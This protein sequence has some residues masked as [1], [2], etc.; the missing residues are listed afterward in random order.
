MGTIFR[1]NNANIIIPT[2]LALISMIILVMFSVFLFKISPKTNINHKKLPIILST[3]RNIPMFWCI[4]KGN[5][6][7]TCVL[8][9]SVLLIKRHSNSRS[10]ALSCFDWLLPIGVQTHPENTTLSK[11]C[12]LGHPNFL[13]L[14]I[15]FFVHGGHSL[16]K[17]DIYCSLKFIASNQITL[18]RPIYI[19]F[20][21][22]VQWFCILEE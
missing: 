18:T 2:A 17:K 21:T 16:D 10:V 4:V 9:L 19:Y 12:C 8:I 15:Q 1:G 7:Q 20:I 22:D 3:R 11:I 14:A 5:W 13:H 6:F